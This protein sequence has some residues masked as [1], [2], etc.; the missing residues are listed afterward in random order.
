MINLIRTDSS[1]AAFVYLVKELDA[2]LTIMDGDEHGFYDQFNKID[3]LKNVVLVFENEE[4]IACG[5]IKAFDETSM[6]VKRMYVSPDHRGKGIAQEI[7][8]E[9]EKWAKELGY[10]KTVLETG[11]RQVE[12]MAL[13]QKCGYLITP[14]YGQYIGVENSVCYSKK[15]G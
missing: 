7:L 5:A 2:Y 4:A 9:L 12:A 6:E 13:Y 8:R 3:A 14:N 15:I 10:Q 1:H 11:K